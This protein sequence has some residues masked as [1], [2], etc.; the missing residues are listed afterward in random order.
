MDTDM[1]RTVL[2]AIPEGRWMSYSDIVAAIGAPPPAARRLNQR[3]IRDE[4]PNAH[5]ILKS[6][7][8][9]ALTALGDPA[10]VRAKL[11]A[12]GIAFDDKDRASQDARIR[13]E[14]PALAETPPA[15]KVPAPA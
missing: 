10:G 11:E 12:E 8:R 1:L 3:L 9:I 4:L 6:D 14:L 15:A 2:E 5:R 7:G 13:P